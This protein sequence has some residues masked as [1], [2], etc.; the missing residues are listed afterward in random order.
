MHH[1]E[2][3]T[4]QLIKTN[5][6]A[7]L[8]GHTKRWSHP[9]QA[10]SGSHVSRGRRTA[11]PDNRQRHTLMTK[12][13]T[14]AKATKTARK[15]KA[16]TPAP[17]AAEPHR[18]AAIPKASK[19]KLSSPPRRQTKQAQFI[20]LLKRKDGVDIATLSKALGWQPHTVRSALSRLK[21]AGYTLDKFSDVSPLR[22]F[23]R[24]ESGSGEA[25]NAAKSLPHG[26]VEDNRKS[27]A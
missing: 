7:G 12:T 17:K 13:A 9:C 15:P 18:A 4:K 8:R 24:I 22:T 25:G 1:R 19:A 10:P 11:C 6:C 2:R 14:K 3:R 20:A 27:A 5:V 23:Y 26:A 21:Q 16:N